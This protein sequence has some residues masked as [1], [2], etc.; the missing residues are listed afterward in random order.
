MAAQDLKKFYAT[1]RNQFIK[2]LYSVLNSDECF[3]YFAKM[4]QD[5]I[6]EE[7]YDR[8]TPKT[9]TRRKTEGGLQDPKNYDYKVSINAKGI[10]IFM[11]NLTKGEG[12][13]FHIDSGIVRGVGFYDWK[14]SEIYALQEQGGYPRDFYTYMEILVE[15]KHNKLHNIIKKQMIKKGWKTK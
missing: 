6:Q 3:N 1:I 15:D 8:Y 10:K 14:D 2:D 7:V 5:S 11:R 12:K 13:A 4:M 9:Y